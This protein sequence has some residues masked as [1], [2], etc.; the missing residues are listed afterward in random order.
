MHRRT[1]LSSLAGGAAVALAHPPALRADLPKM[2]IKRIRFYQNPRSR[3][4]FNQSFNIVTVETDS[5]ITG[6]GEGGSRDT[7]AE[8]AEMLIGDEPSKIDYLWQLVYRGRFYPAGREKLDALGALDL[9]LWDI[10]GKA[11]GV[12]VYELLGR[13]SR[14]HI[15]CYSTGFPE[16]G[17]LKET[18]RACVE[19]GFRAFRTAVA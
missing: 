7:V 12:P 4:M 9:A 19:A 13:Q 15:E 8:C 11:L 5:G 3:P 1:F 2:K 6:I 16:K 10:K 17:S 14:E 18:A